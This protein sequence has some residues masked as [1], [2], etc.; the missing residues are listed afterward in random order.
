MRRLASMVT[1]KQRIPFFTSLNGQSGGYNVANTAVANVAQ[2][3]SAK[4]ANFFAQQ[5]LRRTV[6]NQAVLL[7]DA[8]D[9]SRDMNSVVDAIKAFR[10][11]PEYSGQMI[12]SCRSNNYAGQLSGF[13]T[14]RIKGYRNIEVLTNEKLNS[15]IKTNPQLR[16]IGVNPFLRGMLSE[17]YAAKGNF[18]FDNWS[19][20]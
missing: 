9:E 5:E 10:T 16:E 12:V 4:E 6:E 11:N 19:C 7:L 18:A 8:L 2:V 17:V 3:V 15:L 1:D 20:F 13:K 14:I